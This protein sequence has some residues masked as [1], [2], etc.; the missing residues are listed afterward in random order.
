[1]S[2]TEIKQP[3]HQALRQ[4]KSDGR[5]GSTWYCWVA[6]G[7]LVAKGASYAI[8]GALA[9]DL[10]ATGG[11]KAT[12]RQGALHTLA[13]SALGKALLVL[14]AIG[15][16]AYAVWRIVQ[17]IAVPTDGDEAKDRAKTWGK[18]AGYL[19][20]AAIYAGLTW[21]TVAIVAGAGGGQSQNQKAHRTTATVL[22]WPG[23]R[24]LVAIAG[25]VVAGVGLWNL[26]RGLARKFEDR[27]RTGEMT[28]TQRRWASRVGLVGHVARFVVFAL[29]GVFVT[30]AAIDYD[31]KEAIGLDGALQK[32]AHAAYGP[33]LLGLT[34]A[35]LVSYGAYCLVDARYRDVAAR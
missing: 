6:R 22:D 35:G 33:W 28:A 24:V 8:V 16:A 2:T 17:A 10:A 14:L 11:G 12:S 34:A 1:V 27:W 30:K 4:V 26:Y 32:L 20:R 31:P 15:F 23:G 19:G 5:T 9:I 18:R 21:S 29:I 3:A 13:G 7:G 25:V